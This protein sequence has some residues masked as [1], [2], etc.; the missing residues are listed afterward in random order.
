MRGSL[1][2]LAATLLVISACGDDPFQQVVDIELPYHEPA[3]AVSVELVAGDTVVRHFVARSYGTQDERPEE[4]LAYE[5][6]LYR[7]DA[8]IL[9]HGGSTN[10]FNQY[11]STRANITLKPALDSVPARY[12]VEVNVAGLGS[13][14][15]NEVMPRQPVARVVSFERDGALSS[16]GERVDAVRLAITD[17]PGEENF[18]AVQV[19]YR[20]IG[21]TSC[22]YSGGTV[23][24]DST[25]A[26]FPIFAETPNPLVRELGYVYRMGLSDS[27]FDGQEYTLDIQF[28]SS[29]AGDDIA[30]FAEVFALTE[31][32][33][34]YLV[35]KEA[36]D[37]AR[38]NPFA[39]PVTVTNNITGGYGYFIVANRRRLPLQ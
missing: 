14:S 13:A 23:T 15:A 37:Q 36:F 11:D 17:P 27:S 6:V 19:G 28:S 1:P 9:R 8:E 24:C 35:S 7:N 32:A 38:G 30:L 3:P 4:D 20:G 10:D 33:F 34:R 39:E 26:D 16:D 22:T 5:L 12:R 2:L 25:Y 18:Y 29:S 31:S 21:A